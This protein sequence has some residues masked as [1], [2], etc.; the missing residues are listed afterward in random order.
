MAKKSKAGR[1][2]V[3]T[4]EVLRKLEEA[5]SKDLSD[6]EACLYAGIGERTLYDY[7]D[8][9]PDFSQ[10]KALLKSSVSMH[11]KLKLAESISDGNVGDAKWY[12]E[13]RQGDDYADTVKLNA[14]VKFVG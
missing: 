1:P 3:M 10:R 5:F 9:N 14:T 6:R 12:L 2:T 7:Q 13:K 8:N 4:P 11:A